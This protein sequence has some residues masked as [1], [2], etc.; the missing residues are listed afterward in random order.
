[1]SE[2]KVNK[3][4]KKPTGDKNV[5]K[6]NWA[7]VAYPESLPADWLDKLRETGLQS[8]ISPLHDKD[9]NP[10]GTVKKMHYHV[11]VTYSG[12]TSFSVVKKITDNL[13]APS[14]Q[15][16]EQ[17]RGYYRYF[18]HKDNPEKYQ[19]SEK[20]IKTINGFNIANFV[21]LTKGEVDEVKRKLMTLIRELDITEYCVFMDYLQDT[22]K[23]LEFNVAS[24]NT[25][26]F[27]KYITSRRN[28]SAAM[29]NVSYK[30]T[31]SETGEVLD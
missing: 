6:R 16:L 28:M 4:T 25:Y 24:S 20:E 11:I 12:P 21:E 1:M 7:F 23:L 2:K 8:V 30:K 13:N 17:I 5:K 15:P 22:D 3:N 10:D 14:P 27:E 19:Y 9:R 31:D 18:T 26:F 29:R